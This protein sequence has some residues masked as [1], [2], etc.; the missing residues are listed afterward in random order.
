MDQLPGKNL[1]YIKVELSKRHSETEFKNKI[2]ICGLQLAIQNVLSLSIKNKHELDQWNDFE[3]SHRPGEVVC[4]VSRSMA[5]NNWA[6]M[7]TIKID[8]DKQKYNNLVT[9]TFKENNNKCKTSRKAGHVIENK[10]F[11]ENTSLLVKGVDIEVNL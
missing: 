8:N 2:L 4:F 9:K 11:I 5:E 3:P 10:A 6:Q 1:D 7:N